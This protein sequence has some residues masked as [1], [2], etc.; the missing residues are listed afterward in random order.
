LIPRTKAAAWSSLRQYISND[1]PPDREN[2]SGLL[3]VPSP[4][5]R[6]HYAMLMELVGHRQEIVPSTKNA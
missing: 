4:W 2:K 6:R 1:F 3:S 5:F